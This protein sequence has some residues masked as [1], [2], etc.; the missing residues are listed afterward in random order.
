MIAG[1][2][3]DFCAGPDPV[4]IYPAADFPLQL[5]MASTGNALEVSR[6]GW[7]ACAPCAEHIELGS[8]DA[9]ALR[10]IARVATILLDLQV[11][12]VTAED[13]ATYIRTNH[14]NFRD[15]RTGARAGFG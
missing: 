13:L 10:A 3:C 4:W 8:D 5:V 12:S 15:H 6:G 9:L 11:V 1:P 7:T 14:D 2:L